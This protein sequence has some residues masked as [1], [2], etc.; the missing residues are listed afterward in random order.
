MGIKLLGVDGPKLSAD[1]NRTQE[2]LLINHP[3]LPV[4]AA[5]EYLAL[6]QAAFAKKPMSY[7]LGGMPWNWKLTALQESI[8]I[9]S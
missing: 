1:E 8:S 3:V 9:R 4:G 2:F 7:F 6:F 5:D